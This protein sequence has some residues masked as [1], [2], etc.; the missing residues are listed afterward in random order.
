MPNNAFP[1][2]GNKARHAEWILQHIPEHECYVEPF[3]GAAGVLFNKPRSKVEVY[4]DIDGDIVHFFEVLR[5]RPEELQSWLERV[6][7]ARELHEKWAT[8]YYEEG[9]RPD[10]DIER[11]GRWFFLRYSQFGAKY[12]GN[13]GFA[14]GPD[15][16]W[17]RAFV[18]RTRDGDFTAFSERL[19]EV[20]VE[21]VDWHDLINRY[22]SP[23]T[24]F[25]CDPPYD[26]TEYQYGSDSFEHKALHDTLAECE[27]DVLVSYDSIPPFYGDGWQVATKASHFQI[28]NTNGDG[29][30]DATEVLLMNFDADGQPLM[31]D[32]G[33]QTIESF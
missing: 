16:K 12:Y 14:T 3:G 10:D 17:R 1:Y 30:K 22:D 7:Y 6:P 2:P 25:Y 18:N 27:A 33:Q 19:R 24:V 8:A 20:Y 5:E 13:S 21:S 28:D 29:M 26:G 23:H 15:D 31:S 32:V 4:N 9:Y 11:A